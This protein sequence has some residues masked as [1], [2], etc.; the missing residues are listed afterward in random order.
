MAKRDPEKTARNKRISQLSDELKE[1]RDEVMEEMGSFSISSLHGVIGGKHAQYIDIKSEVIYSPEDF[2]ARW[3][4]GFKEHVEVIENNYYGKED[5]NIYRLHQLLKANNRSVKEYLYKFLSRTYLKNY[6]ALSKKRPS[7]EEAEIWIGQTN[8]NY[9]LLVTPRF[10][11]FGKWENDKSE[12]RHFDRGYFTIN[13][14][15]ETGL[16]IPGK[17]KRMNFDSVDEYLDFF[18]EVIVRNS[19]S[20]YEYEIAELYCNFVRQSEDPLKIPLLIPEFRYD[21]LKKKHKY[22][23]DF[24][25]IDP[26]DFN[27]IGF[28]LSPWSTHGYLSKTK[29]LNQKQ[30]NEI[31]KGNFEKEME[32]HKAFFR[33]HNIFTLIYTDSDLADIQ[34]V[35]EDMKRYLEPKQIQ[36]QLQLHIIDEFFG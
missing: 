14:V 16:L 35:F 4:R 23:L 20:K 26:V 11:E 36:T 18:L 1:L 22:R 21:G 15:L 28:E 29:A 5:S 2:I 3:L 17:D 7:I 34:N 27:K 8:A 25:I 31:A 9:G 19:G 30:I 24:T 33:K 12:I 13:H 6:E 10:N 32:K